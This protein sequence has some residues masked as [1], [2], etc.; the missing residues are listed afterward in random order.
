MWGMWVSLF[1][2]VGFL[3]GDGYFYTEYCEWGTNSQ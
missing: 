3:W 1:V 2:D